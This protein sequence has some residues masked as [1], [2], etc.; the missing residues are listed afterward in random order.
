MPEGDTV[1]RT[2]ARLHLALA[3]K[4]LSRTD[5]R[6]PKYA[7]TDLRGARVTA[8]RSVGKHLFIDVATDRRALSIHTHLKM[9]GVWHAHPAG[10]RWRRPA[11][12]A[13]VVLT[14]D[15]AG[16]DSPGASGAGA[17][18]AGASRVEAVGFSLS[19]VELTGDPDA[20]VAHLGPDLLGPGWDPDLAAANLA[21]A[22]DR[23][24]GLALLDQ[25]TLAGVGNI[26]R[27][28]VCFL[29]GVH[30]LTPAGHTDL[31]DVVAL[32]H[33]LLTANR[34]RGLR[35]TTGDPRRSGELWVYDRHRRPCRRCGTPIVREYLSER[36]RDPDRSIYR[37]PGCQPGPGRQKSRSGSGPNS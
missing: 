1:Y 8:V 21:A 15:G 10:T 5:F 35:N 27:S 11:H 17:G 34:D 33:R 25:R 7:T 19:I 16:A 4:T 36:P 2:A 13:R 30:P 9:D 12:T 3:G 22:P 20:T 6:V 28:E 26:Y 24:I 32:C 23:P 29:L 37:C 14:A 31:P 18:C